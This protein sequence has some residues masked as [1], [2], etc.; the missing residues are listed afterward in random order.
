MRFCPFCAQEN[1]DDSRE[2][3]HCGKRLPAA[4]T[5]P[6]RPAAPPREKPA[7]KVAPRPAPRSLPLKPAEG[8]G[9]QLAEDPP[10]TQVQ[11]P[12]ERPRF[13]TPAHFS[14]T[15][16]P[17]PMAPQPSPLPSSEVTK[18]SALPKDRPASLPAPLPP[19]PSSPT[20]TVLGM[21]APDSERRST[22]PI[23]VK[24]REIPVKARE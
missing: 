9:A 18:P 20:G 7:P 10:T 1:P 3:V 19:P 8:E 22:K 6:P 2:C 11:M 21:S 12:P 4:R 24:A 14:P 5:P 17:P 15:P 13:P 16:L 23:P